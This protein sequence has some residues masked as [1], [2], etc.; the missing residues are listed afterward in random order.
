MATELSNARQDLPHSNS[1]NT[2]SSIPRITLS[3]TFRSTVTNTLWYSLPFFCDVIRFIYCTALQYPYTKTAQI[4]FENFRLLARGHSGQQKCYRFQPKVWSSDLK[5]KLPQNIL[6]PFLSVI[7]NDAA[8]FF[9]YVASIVEEWV[10]S[11]NRMNV[12]GKNQECSERTLCQ[13]QLFYHKSY[14]DWHWDR[15]L[16][17]YGDSSG[18]IMAR[19]LPSFNSV[20]LC[21]QFT[22]H[23]S[24]HTLLLQTTTFPYLI[25]DI[26]PLTTKDL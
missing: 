10:R 19:L 2:I 7:L 22:C 16:S 17:L 25:V 26:N 24:S 5:N 8:S 4:T 12:R 3:V 9:G 13:F 15:N 21:Q 11:N 1:L 6:I 14:K 18:W 20:A 23:K